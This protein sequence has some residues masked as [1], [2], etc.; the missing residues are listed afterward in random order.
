MSSDG[1]KTI[2]RTKRPVRASSRFG[3]VEN[4]AEEGVE[5]QDKRDQED[6]G[7]HPAEAKQHKEAQGRRS[8]KGQHKAGEKGVVQRLGGGAGIRRFRPRGSHQN[9]PFP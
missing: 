5:E 7:N 2:P 9:S 6:Y 8:S 3:P 4:V 1:S